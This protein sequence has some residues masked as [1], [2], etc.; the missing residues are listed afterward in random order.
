MTAR[1][2]PTPIVTLP[3]IVAFDLVVS[4][5]TLLQD[6]LAEL[7]QCDSDALADRVEAFMDDIDLALSRAPRA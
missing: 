3:P 5:R 2:L 1:T 7:A 4:A 6:C